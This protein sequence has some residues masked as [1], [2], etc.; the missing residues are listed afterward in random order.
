MDQV[1]PYNLKTHVLVYL[2]DLLVMSSSFEEHLEHLAVVS[3]QL[4]KAGLTINISKSQFCLNRIDYL[5]YVIEEGT[6][7]I[8]P[9]KIQAVAEFP[10][11]KTRKQLRRFLGMTGWY[12]RFISQYSTVI[13][14][15]TELLRGKAFEWNEEAQVAFDE[16]KRRLCTAPFLIHPNYQK[17]FILQCD[18]SLYG[19]GAVLAQ[20]DETGC[21]RPIA[22]MSKNLIKPNVTIQ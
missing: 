11:P 22:Y 2:D 21:E 9:D 6:L 1:I 10:V 5:G 20:V 12:Q 7:H 4:H 16:I 15:L 3:T 14:P 18:A 8:N 13:F 17:P 19:V